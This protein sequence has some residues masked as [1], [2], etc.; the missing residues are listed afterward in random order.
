MYSSPPASPTW[1]RR[2]TSSAA[3]STQATPLYSESR[4]SS[5]YSTGSRRS[6]LQNQSISG[7]LGSSVLGTSGHNAQDNLATELAGAMDEEESI[8]EGVEDTEPSQLDGTFQQHTSPPL[9]PIKAD[10]ERIRDSGIHVDSSPGTKTSAQ[11][12]SSQV[13][14]PSKSKHSRTQSRT[15]SRKQSRVESGIPKHEDHNQ[16]DIPPSLQTRITE[17]EAL[18]RQGSN[19]DDTIEEVENPMDQFLSSLKD[20]GGQ[21]GSLE[22]YATRLI[23]THTSLSM[24]LA[25]QRKTLQSLA[26]FILSPLPSQPLFDDEDGGTDLLPLIASVMN[27]T[28]QPTFEALSGLHRLFTTTRELTSSLSSLSDSLHMSRQI[29]STATRR[30]KGAKEVV[31]E[32]SNELRATE[33]GIRWIEEG[34]WDSKLERREC[35]KVCK[36]VVGGFEEVCNGWKAKLE[37]GAGAEVGVA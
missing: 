28:P 26:H 14:Q 31:A 18:A 11:M 30:L 34:Q 8:K 1:R 7:D 19:K 10:P 12:S 37:Q 17:I 36:D 23:T 15:H 2:R 35:A 20:L 5:H 16:E 6:S 32:M 24:H 33:D 13:R 22:S 27:A 9:S 25:H 21:Q 3:S 4:R 29:T